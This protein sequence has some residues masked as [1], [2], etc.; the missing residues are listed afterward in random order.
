LEEREMTMTKI[1]MQ[2]VKR[3]ALIAHDNCKEDIIEWARFNKDVL[4]RH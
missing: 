2:E 1:R 3:I 4:S